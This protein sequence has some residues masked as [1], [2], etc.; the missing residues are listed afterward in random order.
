M[1]N[2]TDESY[3]ELNFEVGIMIGETSM[4]AKIFLASRCEHLEL[5]RFVIKH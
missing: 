5:P 3:W 4:Q 2:F 1:N